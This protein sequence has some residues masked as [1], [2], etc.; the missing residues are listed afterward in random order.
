MSKNNMNKDIKRFIVK[1]DNNIRNSMKAMDDAGQGILIIYKDNKVFGIVTDGD[2]RRA[3]LSGILA[4]GKLQTRTL[5]LFLT[6]KTKLKLKIFS[7]LQK[8]D[9]FLY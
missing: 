9:I 1:F 6:L 2:I 8:H 3:I 5:Y 7:R 4:L